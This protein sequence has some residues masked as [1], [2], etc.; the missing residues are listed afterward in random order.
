MKLQFSTNIRHAAILIEEGEVAPFLDLKDTRY[1][2][3]I[4]RLL[5]TV[6]WTPFKISTQ[7]LAEP[8]SYRCPYASHN[9]IFDAILGPRSKTNPTDP[10]ITEW[11]NFPVPEDTGTVTP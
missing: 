3:Q 7:E 2:I 1:V 6:I 11:P 8:H 4:D 10:V 9:I 5:G